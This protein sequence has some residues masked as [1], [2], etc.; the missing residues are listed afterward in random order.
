MTCAVCRSVIA[1]LLLL[2]ATAASAAAQCSIVA[3]P[4]LP[5]G[6]FSEAT[7]INERGQIVGRSDTASEDPDF[8]AVLWEGGE[9]I[10]LGT[11]PG[12]RYSYAT[13]INNKGQIVGVSQTTGN[14]CE[15]GFFTAC[16]HAFV[17]SDG[18]MTDLGAI[19]GPFSGAT[20]INDRGQVVGFSTTSAE[21]DTTAV[22]WDN[23]TMIDLGRL[24]GDGF[25]TA[26]AINNRGQIVGWSSNTTT[27]AFIWQRGMMAELAALPGGEFSL[28]ADLNNTGRIVGVGDD[29]GRPPVMWANRVP[30]T[31]PMLPGAQ[32]GQANAINNGGVAAGWVTFPSEDV[33]AVVWRR[34]TVAR[35][36]AL[37]VPPN[38]SSLSM[39]N[40]TNNR[41][42][43]VGHSQGRAVVW[44]GCG[45]R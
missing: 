22:L 27:R 18:V 20:G 1:A 34:A 6:V 43:I 24:P 17:W 28:A 40:D 33:Y 4:T 32:S 21:G 9:V 11:L 38:F 3:L 29:G 14:N 36:P 30:V 8:H 15:A 39:A 12:G 45:T 37:P 35:L 2:F 42:D 44:A 19:R 23:G 16:E 5:G 31:L 10:D 25:A 13:G 7:A 26:G 41:G